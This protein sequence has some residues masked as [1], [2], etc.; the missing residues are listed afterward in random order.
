[1]KQTTLVLFLS[2]LIPATTGAS[3]TQAG[4]YGNTLQ[5]QRSMSGGCQLDTSRF[6]A[7][8]NQGTSPT[9]ATALG[10]Q[11]GDLYLLADCAGPLAQ[12]A[13][14]NN[15]KLV[16]DLTDILFD[17]VTNRDLRLNYQTVMQTFY[18][19]AQASAAA[20]MGNGFSA[21]NVVTAVY[22][23]TGTEHLVDTGI[24]PFHD[25]IF[26]IAAGTRTTC[27]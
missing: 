13:S 20:Y 9:Y 15:K 8:R 1:M 17:P 16:I 4:Y 7:Q 12:F 2:L 22:N 27:E 18:N 11:N 24:L 14:A 3:I 25:A 5:L 6:T 26:D 10:N 23:L 21:T 19:R